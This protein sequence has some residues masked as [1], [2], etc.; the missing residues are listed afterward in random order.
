LNLMSLPKPTVFKITNHDDSTTRR[1]TMPTPTPSWEELSTKIR[2]IFEI[3]KQTRISLTYL[4]EEGDVITF[5]S[6]AELQDLYNE[7]ECSMQENHGELIRQEMT[8]LRQENNPT[9]AIA[10]SNARKFGLKIYVEK[11]II[12]DVEK[13]IIEDE[14]EDRNN[15]AQQ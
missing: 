6:E 7:R 5:S 4:D 12:E 3:P 11:Q 15:C 13:Q 8:N 14:F 10:N 2:Q 9:I 1:F